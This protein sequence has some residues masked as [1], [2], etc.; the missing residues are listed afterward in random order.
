MPFSR[1]P[2]AP[3]A[4][5]NPVVLAL[6]WLA[7]LGMLAQ[8]WM[9]AYGHEHDHAFGDA[10]PGWVDRDA[11][12]AALASD[13]HEHAHRHTSDP[14]ADLQNLGHTHAGCPSPGLPSTWSFHGAS[15]DV[16]VLSAPANDRP[17]GDGHSDAPFRPPIV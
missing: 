9:L 3:R 15:L 10:V 4:R 11:G 1:P 13:E 14:D 16:A 2:A 12:V 17:P 7:L 6:V 8:Q 5:L